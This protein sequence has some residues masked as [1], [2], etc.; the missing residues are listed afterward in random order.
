MVLRLELQDQLSTASLSSSHF[1]TVFD[2][3]LSAD[4]WGRRLHAAVLFG[5][6]RFFFV[7]LFLK[8]PLLVNILNSSHYM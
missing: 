2:R 1:F 7:F 6:Q 3:W 5:K 8:L 4:Q